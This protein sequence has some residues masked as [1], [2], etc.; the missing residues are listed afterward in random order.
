MSDIEEHPSSVLKL[1]IAATGAPPLKSSPA[2]QLKHQLFPSLAL[3]LIAKLVEDIV[4]VV[5]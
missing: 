1:H 4:N 2:L 5:S 3:G